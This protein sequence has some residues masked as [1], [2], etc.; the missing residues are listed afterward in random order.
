MQRSGLI[1]AGISLAVA[2]F[3]TVALAASA[4]SRRTAADI[5]GTRY[6]EVLELKGLPPTA[7]ATVWNTIGFSHCP[8][9]QWNALDPAAIAAA[10]GD[11]A[12]VL[13]GPRYWLMDAASGRTGRS[14][15]FGGLR[16]R[17]VATIP[18][19]T[20]EE[21]AQTPYSEHTIVRRNTWKWNKGRTI[22]ELHAPGGATYVMQSYSQIKDPTES[23]NDLPGLGSR[24]Q[25]PA[26]WRYGTRKLRQDLV[27]AT[28]GRAT[29]VQ[30]ELLNTYQREP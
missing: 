7:Q 21:L 24:L 17:Q 28:H 8:A 11:T 9:A 19:R 1:L 15:V 27:L 22:Y 2:F 30:D 6:C 10:R 5:Y 3:L 4:A 12:I 16:F 18:I 14:Q 29:V 23:V 20:N 25:L 13:N 26:G